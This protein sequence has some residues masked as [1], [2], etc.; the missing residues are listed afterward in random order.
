MQT[1]LIESYDKLMGFA[2]KHLWDKFFLENDNRVSLRNIIA[3]EMLANTL[4]HR[5]MTSSYI[6]KFVIEKSRMFVEN[7][8]R[9]VKVNDGGLKPFVYTHK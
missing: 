9:A 7:A 3:R 6:S 2:E 8:N 1:N 5:E 4:I